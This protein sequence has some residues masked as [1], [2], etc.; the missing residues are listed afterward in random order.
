MLLRGALILPALASLFAWSLALALANGRETIAPLANVEES[1]SGYESHPADADEP[2]ALLAPTLA[3][4]ATS[5]A[6]AR[7]EPLARTAPLEP[8]D[9]ATIV[10]AIEAAAREFGQD[11]DLLVRVAKCESRLNPVAVGKAGEI[12]I[13]QFKSATFAKNA[14]KLGYSL[15]DIW[16]VRAQARVSAEM[17]GRAQQWQWTCFRTAR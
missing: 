12:G 5:G 15:A 7:A 11:P 2:I 8:P 3:S 13:F 1:P 10:A 9:H 6:V 4:D 14:A 17:F 16:D